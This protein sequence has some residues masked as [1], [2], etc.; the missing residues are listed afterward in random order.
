MMKVLETE[1][2]IS[3]HNINIKIRNKIK[4]VYATVLSSNKLIL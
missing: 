4:F 1:H 2:N 3:Y